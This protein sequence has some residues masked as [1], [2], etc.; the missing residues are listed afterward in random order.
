VRRL[1]DR[2]LPV[3]RLGHRGC[4]IRFDPGEVESWI[5]SNGASGPFA[6]PPKSTEPA[7]IKRP[8]TSGALPPGPK[9]PPVTGKGVLR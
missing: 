7:T 8:R 3:V 6:R 1:V 2:G 5:F 4:S 9:K